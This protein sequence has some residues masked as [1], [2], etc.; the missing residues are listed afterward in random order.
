MLL[1]HRGRGTGYHPKPTETVKYRKQVS[2]PET[3]VAGASRGGNAQQP[4][5][6]LEAG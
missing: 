1:P 3:E 5:Q 6:I 2:F 4:Q